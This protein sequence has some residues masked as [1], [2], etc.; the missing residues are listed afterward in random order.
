MFH[1]LIMIL[2]YS[3]LMTDDG[4]HLLCVHPP[5]ENIYSIK[6]LLIHFLISP[7]GFNDFL[8]LLLTTYSLLHI[9]HAN[10]VGYEG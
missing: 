4:E 8:L 10:W 5:S 2:I 6:C 3:F 1:V 9:L 7:N